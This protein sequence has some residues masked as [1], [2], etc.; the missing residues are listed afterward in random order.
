MSA[1]LR[2][3]TLTAL[4]DALR[5]RE[6]SSV[7]ATRACLDAIDAY[8]PEINS[9]IA[10]ERDA[11]LAQATAADHELATGHWRGPLHGVPLAHKDMFYRAGKI[12]SCGSAL[13]VDRVA[14][15]TATVQQ[16]MADA[17]SVYVGSLNMSE[18]AAGPTGHNVH[19]GH[20]RN[21]WNPAHVTGGSSSGSGAA[22]AARLI[23]GSLGSDT[24]GSIRLPAAMCGVVGVKPT[25]GLV[26]R[27]GVMP[28]C[29]SLDVVGPLARTAEDCALLLQA[30]AGRDARDRTTDAGPV[31]DY[32][33]RVAGAVAG[34]TIGVPTNAVFADV[35][36]PVRARL[37]ASLRA[38]EAAG[39]RVVPVELPDPRVIYALTNLVNKAE[40]ASVHAQWMRTRRSEYSL[41]A[42]NRIEAGFH[43]AATH[44]LDALR[45]RAP[46][47]EKFAEQV[48][49]RV[50]AVHMP[51]LGM[52]VPTI[53]ATEIRSTQDVPALMERITRFT[54]WVNYLGLPA[55][56]VP[57]GFTDDGLPVAFQLLGRPFAEARLLR[58]AHAYQQGTDWHRR[59][60]ALRRAAADA[61][62][63]VQS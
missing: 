40:A 17:G 24:G 4:S 43:V 26:S 39:A 62:Q 41:S 7:E 9:F 48:F 1:D 30:V 59:A 27:Y 37:D 28:R 46:L 47:L 36:P 16:R 19:F 44:Y 25:Y 10:V 31:P 55:V 15:V 56:S 35:E 51:V 8:D 53:D 11:A 38:L 34:F 22:V 18:F 13:C 42:A 49:A 33:A 63:T 52:P 6:V 29:W 21:P 2:A 57:C 54:R 23:Y 14:T 58:L 45:L 5:R 12:S 61:S 32:R 50:D 20:C 3:L 60:P